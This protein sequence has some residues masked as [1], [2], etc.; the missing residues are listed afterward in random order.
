MAILPVVAYHAAQFA[1]ASSAVPVFA[2]V[3]AVLRKVT[4]GFLGVDVFFVISGFLITGLL[5]REAEKDR[6]IHAGRFYARRARRILPAATVTL[7]VTLFASY[8]ILPAARAL[9]TA[10]DVL[11][12]ALF[13]ADVHFAVSGI[14]YMGVASAPSPVLHFWSLNDEEKFYVVWPALVGLVTWVCVRRRVASLRP[15]LGGALIALG[16]ASLWWSQHLVSLGDPSAYFSAASRAFELACGGLVAISWPLVE[17]VPNVVRN[18][19]AM[20]G[21]ATVLGCMLT[22]GTL[23]PFPGLMAVPVVAATAL[24][25]AGHPSGG[26]ARLLSVRPARWVGRISY[27][28]YLW[29]WPVLVLA[30]AAAGGLLGASRVMLWVAVAFGLAWLSYRFVEQPPQRWPRLRPTRSALLFGLALILTTVVAALGVGRLAQAQVTAFDAKAVQG[31]VPITKVDRGLLWIGDSVTA[32]GRGPLELALKAA[33]WDFQVNAL[34][35]RPIISGARPSWT[36]LCQAKPACGADLVLGGLGSGVPATVVVD[37]GLNSEEPEQYRLAPPSPT[38]SGLR[39]RT[40]AAGRLVLKGQDTP[41]Q[42]AAGVDKLMHLV[43]RG[44]NVYFVAVWLDDSIWGN[45]T[46]RQTNLALKT[47]AAKYPNAHFLDWAGYVDRTHVPYQ[48]DGSHPTPDG[49][50]ERARWLVT[51]LR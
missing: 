32:R 3:L 39:N 6:R 37:L 50:V 8:A 20:L 13:N 35:G 42:I 12:A 43:P 47:T 11:W 14:D 26:A 4:G 49:M 10:T 30:S 36:P 38:D 16:G 34:G 25:L 28:L 9:T 44:T 15:A 7:L 21:L 40:D 2:V 51:Q 18:V 24:V 48:P 19:G 27:S 46:W 33:G 23:T 31:I 17:R 29:H 1:S 5:V 45:V 41:A 22:Y